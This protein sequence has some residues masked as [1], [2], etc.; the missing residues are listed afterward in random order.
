MVCQWPTAGRL[1]SQLTPALSLEGAS[2]L[3]SLSPVTEVLGP[4]PWQDGQDAK[5][6]KACHLNLRKT[7]LRSQAAARCT[8][9]KQGWGGYKT[10]TW[11]GDEE[12]GTNKIDYT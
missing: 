2:L 9:T 11:V 7:F 8:D 6:L 4:S 10:R 1:K 5:R 3:L 12:R